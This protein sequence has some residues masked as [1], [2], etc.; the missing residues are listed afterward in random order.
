ME[1]TEPMGAPR[2]MIEASIVHVQ[3]VIEE[4]MHQLYASPSNHGESV[5][6]SITV[7]YTGVVRGQV[8]TQKLV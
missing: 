7:R 4:A 1:V 2:E 8:I 6:P 5:V 3:K